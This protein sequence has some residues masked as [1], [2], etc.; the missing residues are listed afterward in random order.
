MTWISVKDRL[1]PTDR[2][3]MAITDQN[4]VCIGKIDERA[5]SDPNTFFKTALVTTVGINVP[6]IIYWC[7]I[8]FCPTKNGNKWLIFGNWISCNEFSPPNYQ[9]SSL[10]FVLFD[11]IVGIAEAYVGTGYES[12]TY[13]CKYYFKDPVC[14]MPFPRLPIDISGVLQISCNG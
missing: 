2:I 4:W 11:G 12:D 8:P 3:I 10:L 7:E 5:V 9:H 14:W 6:G 13:S 1:P